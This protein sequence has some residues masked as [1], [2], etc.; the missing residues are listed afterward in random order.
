MIYTELR[1]FH[2]VAKFGGFTAAAKAMNISQPTLST[3]VKAL[4]NRYEIELFSRVG[5]EAHLTM[6]GEELLKATTRWKQMETEVEDL[7]NSL[8]GLHSG[9]LRIAAVGPFHATDIIVAYKSNYPG[10][11]VTVQFGNSQRCFERLVAMEADVGVIAEVAADP[12]VSTIPY[13]EHKVVVFVN[14][15]HPFYQR[16]SISIHELSKQKVIQR[17]QGST[18]R[19]AMEHALVENDV[20]IDPVM[21][22]GSREGIWKAVEQGLGI[23]FVADFEFTPHPN[24]KAIPIHDTDIATRYYL[25]F[26]KERQP[27]RLVQSFCKTAL[28]L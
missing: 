23:G 6:A 27:S 24:L 2:I 26:L 4:E 10:I 21:D 8:K 5:R 7:L 12:L 22:I 19:S 17:E 16:D 28:E 3:Q 13:S 15:S 11:D 9:A 14:S 1:A 25:A 20:K 18:T